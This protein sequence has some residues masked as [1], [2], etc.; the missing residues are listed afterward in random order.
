MTEIVAA[1]IFII[2]LG[3]IFTEKWHRMVVSGVGAATMV[4]AG[5]LLDFYDEEHAVEAVEFET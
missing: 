4:A 5:L 3:L 2:T 1:S